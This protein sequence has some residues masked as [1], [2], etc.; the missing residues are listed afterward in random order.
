MQLQNNF[1]QKMYNMMQTTE[2]NSFANKVSNNDIVKQKLQEQEKLQLQH[3]NFMLQLRK[4]SDMEYHQLQ[5][6]IS[7]IMK[8]REH[9]MTML[10]ESI[11]I[12]MKNDNLI[13][14]DNL[15]FSIYSALKGKKLISNIFY[16]FE[17]NHKWC[18]I[19]SLLYKILQVIYPSDNNNSN[20]INDNISSHILQER[21]IETKLLLSISDVNYI[22]ILNI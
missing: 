7:D 4:Q 8:E 20:N 14:D 18:I 9:A 17:P 13:L 12:T 3:H 19:P 11:G 10:L 16:L 1:N 15:F 5:I 21:E 2:I 6:M 22:Y